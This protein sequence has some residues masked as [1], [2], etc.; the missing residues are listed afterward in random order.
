MRYELKRGVS[1]LNLEVEGLKRGKEQNK[2]RTSFIQSVL[3]SL[4]TDR[5]SKCIKVLYSQSR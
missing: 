3:R 1:L 4:A 2:P 5:G